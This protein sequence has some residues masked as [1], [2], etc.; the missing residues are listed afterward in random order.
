MATN[1]NNDAQ[2]LWS[3]FGKKLGLCISHVINMFDP[4]AISIGGGLSNA[5]KYFHNP[6]LNNIIKYSPAYLHYDIDIFESSSKEL[7]AKRGAALSV[8]K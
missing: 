8:T 1:D 5:F 2:Q 4:D 7:S 3:E 6:M